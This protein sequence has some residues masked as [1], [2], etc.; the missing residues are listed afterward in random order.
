[1]DP[2]MSHQETPRPSDS[3]HEFARRRSN[4]SL[5]FARR[6]P[7]NRASV[8]SIDTPEPKCQERI[9]YPVFNPDDPRHNPSGRRH[10][11]QNSSVDS[12]K[13]AHW[14]QDLQRRSI[15]KVRSGLLSLRE[16]LLRLSSWKDSD[17]EDTG[18]MLER[19]QN[20]SR[21]GRNPA[22]GFSS[23][24]D[25]STQED[26]NFGIGMC[27][28][29]S[30]WPST[31]R[32]PSINR[33]TRVASSLAL[34]NLSATELQ[35]S[36]GQH[37]PESPSFRKV[38][39]TS[40]D[41]PPYSTRYDK[42]LADGLADADTDQG[43]S[44]VD[45]ERSVDGDFSEHLD[46]SEVSD[47][48]TIASGKESGSS[49]NG[50]VSGARGSCDDNTPAEQ[51]HAAV[52]LLK[53]PANAKR[54]KTVSP[55]LPHKGVRS[56]D[57][58]MYEE[59]T[60]S[61]MGS[62][63]LPDPDAP[64]SFSPSKFDHPLANIRESEALVTQERL[65]IHRT[66]SEEAAASSI[67][68]SRKCS[69]NV[70]KIAFPG[71]YHALLEQWTRETRNL[72]VNSA[73]IGGDISPLSHIPDSAAEQNQ[74]DL[75]YHEL[76]WRCGNRTHGL[77]ASTSS[78]HRT[79]GSSE[80]FSSGEH[81]STTIEDIWVQ[82]G[83]PSRFRT[84]RPARTANLTRSSSTAHT[85]PP[86]EMPE[87]NTRHSF[88]LHIVQGGEPDERTSL[89]DQGHQDNLRQ[90]SYQQVPR[91]ASQQAPTDGQYTSLSAPVTG[92]PLGSPFDQSEFSSVWTNASSISPG[93]TSRT[94]I[95][96]MPWS[97]M[98]SPIDEEVL[99]SNTIWRDEY[100]MADGKTSNYYPDRGDQPTKRIWRQRLTDDG[101]IHSGPGLDRT[102]SSRLHVSELMAPVTLPRPCTSLP[103]RPRLERE[104]SGQPQG[105]FPR[106]QAQ[107]GRL[108]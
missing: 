60:N 67:A 4:F 69:V 73:E 57:C 56:D 30:P 43:R 72:F 102:P 77:P 23:I 3:S 106:H 34:P 11:C 76:P 78:G 84:S 27:R 39:L 49:V 5:S 63:K 97:P 64:S 40:G 94:S 87:L 70:V 93:A 66:K 107:T 85:H 28:M 9:H 22:F 25:V 18:S 54:C 95:S 61:S 101:S 44:F 24:S 92:G 42:P 53:I 59:T 96:N 48:E 15:H 86:E 35:V 100:Y 79:W 75:N 51:P 105:N 80:S 20:H 36:S 33:S 88:G 108:G 91:Q 82:A 89:N 29:N 46:Q 104:G 31:F 41:A 19:P 17:I 98:D 10:Y 21:E 55:D 2:N 99:F 103:N 74:Q 58:P 7:K 81:S 68:M 83:P 71:V 45:T 37:R 65:Q 50:D 26:M 90:S 62:F 47:W 13:Q 1:M 16:G 14:V 38:N 12:Q 6:S 32:E 8:L 52:T